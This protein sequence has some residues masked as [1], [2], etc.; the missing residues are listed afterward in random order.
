MIEI[1][2][3]FKNELSLPNTVEEAVNRLLVILSESECSEIASMQED[4][5]FELHFCLGAAI[6][7]AF[8]LHN[9]ASKL[10]SDCSTGI[11][12][13]DASQVI[14]IALWKRLKTGSNVRLD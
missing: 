7:N 10:L 13:D 9:P 12:P 8:E 4:E 5:L 11:H 14:I 6:R 1:D 2:A 3:I